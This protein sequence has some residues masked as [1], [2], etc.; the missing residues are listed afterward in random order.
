VKKQLMS[1]AQC[2]WIIRNVIVKSNF[3]RRNSKDSTCNTPKRSGH[4]KLLSVAIILSKSALDAFD[5]IYIAVI[6]WIPDGRTV[7]KQAK[8]AQMQQML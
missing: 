7:L 4:D 1:N 2:P 8:D 5:F 3:R 6:A